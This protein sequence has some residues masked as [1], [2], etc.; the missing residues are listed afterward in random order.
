MKEKKLSALFGVP[1]AAGICLA[2]LMGGCGYTTRASSLPFKTVYVSP[3]SNKIDIT[4]ETDSAT[5]YKVY[6]PMLETDVTKALTSKFLMDG[7]LRPVKEEFAEV[8]L[9]GE[10]VEFRRDPL[11]YTESDDVEEYRI[12]ISVNMSLWDNK[13]KVLLW[14]EKY[15][16][17]DSTYFTMG[18]A[19]KSEVVAVNDA[20]NDLARRIV[21]RCVEEW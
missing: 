3:F 8:V 15:F 10:V 1:V 16:T 21:E 5:K 18:T 20:I 11:R 7:N 17:G 14:E 2:F 9:R 4:R 6:R 12:N 13:K 19:Q